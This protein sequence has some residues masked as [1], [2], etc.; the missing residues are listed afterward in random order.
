MNITYSECVS[1]TLGVRRAVRM[2]H[3]VICGLARSTI[4]FHAEDFYLVNGTIFEKKVTEPNYVLIFS[5]NF[6]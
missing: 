2:R 1:A 4:F 5:T 6:V 3:V